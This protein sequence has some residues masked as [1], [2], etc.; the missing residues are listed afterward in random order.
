MNKLS[1]RIELATF[2]PTTS[3]REISNDLEF[4]K[5]ALICIEHISLYGD[6]DEDKSDSLSVVYRMSHVSLGRC[7]AN[8][9]DWV[10]LVN[11]MYDDLMKRGE[12]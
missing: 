2:L 7:S 6:F 4:M 5:K 12:V 1:G 11:D 9:D 3:T 10:E 8:H